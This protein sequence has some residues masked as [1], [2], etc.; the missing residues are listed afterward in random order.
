MV[1][2]IDSLGPSLR[3]PEG[4]IVYLSLAPDLT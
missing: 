1:N 3:G 4:A 2:S